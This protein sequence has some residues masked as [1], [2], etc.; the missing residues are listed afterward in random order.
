MWFNENC[1]KKKARAK[2]AWRKY[3]RTG[4]RQDRG[5]FALA[6]R[7][8]RRTLARAKKDFFDHKRHELEDALARKDM[9][10]FWKQIKL[11]KRE[12]S[13]ASSIRP[14]DWLS[15]FD[16]VMNHQSVSRV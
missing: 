13:E 2:L 8:Y 9:Q 4:C 6:K 12:P 15:H 11:N 14:N 3:S 1:H 16:K 7:D 10:Y 5:R